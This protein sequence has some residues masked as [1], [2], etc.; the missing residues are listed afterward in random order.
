MNLLDEL[1][2]LIRLA[3]ERLATV[4]PYVLLTEAEWEELFG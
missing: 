3:R 1:D 2:R 4:P